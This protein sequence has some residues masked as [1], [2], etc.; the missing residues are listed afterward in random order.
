MAWP[1]VPEVTGWPAPTAVQ[2]IAEEQETAVRALT[3]CPEST[4][5]WIAQAEP[6]QLSTSVLTSVPS[7][8]PTAVQKL[9]PAQETPFSWTAP[10]APTGLGTVVASHLVPPQRR[11][12]G[13]VVPALTSW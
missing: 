13:L 8:L 12:R 1:S 7:A 6:F 9:D 11:A 10:V 5:D 2:T 4:E 3:F